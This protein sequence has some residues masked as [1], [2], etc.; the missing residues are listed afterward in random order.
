[1]LSRSELEKLA[2]F[3][4]TSGTVTVDDVQACVGESAASS[5]DAVVNAAFNGDRPALERELTRAFTEGV[6]AVSL[7]RAIARHLQ[8]LHLARA[9]VSKGNSPQ[10]AMRFLK[11]PVFFKQADNFRRQ[12]QNWSEDKISTALEMVTEAEIDCKSTGFPEKAICSR[13]FMRITQA[14]RRH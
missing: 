9:Y 2:L 10:Q 8:R 14:A 3:M 4:G 5:L 7:L 1:M 11:P 12:M 13:T 6:V